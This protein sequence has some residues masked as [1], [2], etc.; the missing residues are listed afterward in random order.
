MENEEDGQGRERRRLRSFSYPELELEGASVVA[1]RNG[2]IAG[3]HETRVGRSRVGAVCAVLGTLKQLV[4]STSPGGVDR[5]VLVLDEGQDVTDKGDTLVAPRR[6][7][8]PPVVL[9]MS[10]WSHRRTVGRSRSAVA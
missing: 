5:A 10:L 1:V 4:G 6:L 8:E 3:D 7:F 2:T 9:P